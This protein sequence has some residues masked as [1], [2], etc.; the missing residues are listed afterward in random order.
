M[1][2]NLTGKNINMSCKARLGIPEEDKLLRML[3][4]E[5]LH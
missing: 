5:S 3:K 4:S 1:A 2:N